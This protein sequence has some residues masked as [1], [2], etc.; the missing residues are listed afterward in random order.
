[1]AGSGKTKGVRAKLRDMILSGRYKPG[2]FLP[3]VRELAAELDTPK[4]SVYVI[5]KMLH[6]EG[7]IQLQPKRRGALI[8]DT[9]N[10]KKTL[11]RFFL[12]P[13]DFGYFGGLAEG[14]KVLAGVCTAAEKRYADMM[15]SFSDSENVIDEIS[16]LYRDDFIQGVVYMACINRDLVIKP[17]E[18]LNI[19]YVVVSNVYGVDAVGCR[20][21]FRNISRRAVTYLFERGHKKIGILHGNLD[22]YIYRESLAG[23]RGAL[24]EEELEYN[25]EW[26]MPVVDFTKRT[27]HVKKLVKLL[28]SDNCPT[29]FYTVRDYRAAIFYAACEEAGIRIPEDVSVISYDNINWPEGPGKGLTTFQ[30]PT[31]ELGESA[32]DMLNEWVTSGRKPRKRLVKPKLIERESVRSI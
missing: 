3:S 25:P 18:E 1:M 5:L 32:L 28:T 6:A 23:F 31:V 4:S 13:S 15:L 21:D 17:L 27:Y 20:Q 11:H 26:V 10:R 24:A 14:S 9:G 2:T 19:P 29:A 30:E 22:E 12:R 16:S 7:L 8:L